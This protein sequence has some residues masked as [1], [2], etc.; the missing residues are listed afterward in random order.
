MLSGQFAAQITGEFDADPVIWPEFQPAKH[1]IL[2]RVAKF[3]GYDLIS[4]AKRHGLF[5]AVS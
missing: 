3:T 2:A 1:R 4:D 5:D